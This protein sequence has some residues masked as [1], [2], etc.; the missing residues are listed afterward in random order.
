[1]LFTFNYKANSKIKQLSVISFL[2]IKNPGA[3]PGFSFYLLTKRLQSAHKAAA[4]VPVV[5]AYEAEQNENRCRSPFNGAFRNTFAK[6]V[7][8]D[9]ADTV[10]NHHAGSS[11]QPN[12]YQA[13]ELR[14]QCNSCQL[15]FIAHLRQK[16]ATATVQNGLMP[17]SLSSPSSLS[18][19]MVHKPK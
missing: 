16:K 5:N 14:C 11:A 17:R 3:E 9:N 12:R 18:P 2:Q 8:N 10:G 7:A 6:H 19:R 1:M 13:L 15:G 4:G